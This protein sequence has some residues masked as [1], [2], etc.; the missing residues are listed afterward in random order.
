LESFIICC[1]SIRAEQKD[2]HSRTGRDEKKGKAQERMEREVE[3]GLQVL[4]VRSWR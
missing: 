4:E 2:L 3:I 1:H